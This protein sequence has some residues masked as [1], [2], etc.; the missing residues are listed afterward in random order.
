MYTYVCMHVRET[1]WRC[2]QIEC[3]LLQERW[4]MPSQIECVLLQIEFVLLYRKD[5]RCLAQW[6]QVYVC[7]QCVRNVFSY[8]KMCSLT[9]KMVDASLNDVRFLCVPNVFLMC[10]YCVLLQERWSMPRRW[11]PHSPPSSTAGQRLIVGLFCS[12][13][14]SLL[15]RNQV[16]FA[17]MA[18]FSAESHGGARKD[19]MCTISE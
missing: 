9:G 13:I 15:L 6:C 4:S 5:D 7:S 8:R 14:C 16:S 10:F 3:V 19:A 18:T 11:Q 1:P 17:I 2:R 12:Q